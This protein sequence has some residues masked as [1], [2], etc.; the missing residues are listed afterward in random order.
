MFLD[1]L[2]G[3]TTLED[4]DAKKKL[5]KE[6]R[7][8]SN[9]KSAAKSRVRKQQLDQANKDLIAHLQHD[10]S[11]YRQAL[12]LETIMFKKMCAAYETVTSKETLTH[13]LNTM[14]VTRAE[15][16][17]EMEQ[18]ELQKNKTAEENFLLISAPS[19][20]MKLYSNPASPMKKRV[21]AEAESELEDR[22]FK[23]T[24]VKRGLDQEFDLAT[25][26]SKRRNL[27]AK[28]KRPEA[29]AY[30]HYPFAQLPS[31]TI[32]NEDPLSLP[33]VETI[34]PMEEVQQQASMQ[35]AQQMEQMNHYKAVE[36]LTLLSS[37]CVDATER[38]DGGFSDINHLM[39]SPCAKR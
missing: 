32:D 26:D 29:A 13:V 17:N 24:R 15:T 36:A 30:C 3:T 21:A 7:K 31:D 28:K 10:L 4:E 38:V 9:K 20:P 5:A 37:V 34:P 19:S 39:E 8:E 11:C 14:V 12:A 22:H 25:P 16:T 18:N 35:E 2:D 6:V 33:A 27:S 1:G 23:N